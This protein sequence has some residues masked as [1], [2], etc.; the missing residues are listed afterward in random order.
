[1]IELEVVDVHVNLSSNMHVDM[2]H[3]ITRQLPELY[4]SMNKCT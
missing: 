1:M 4:P 2:V 3:Q